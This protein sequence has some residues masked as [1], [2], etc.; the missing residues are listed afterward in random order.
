[1]AVVVTLASTALLALSLAKSDRFT[2]LRRKISLRPY[3]APWDHDPDDPD[4]VPGEYSVILHNGCTFE[5]HKETVDRQGVDLDSR[6]IYVA[7]RTYDCGAI[8]TARLDDSALAIVRADCAVDM[9]ECECRLRMNMGDSTDSDDSSEVDNTLAERQALPEPYQ[10]PLVPA[11]GRNMIPGEFQVILH[12]RCTLDEHKKH[13]GQQG[14][15]LES[16]LTRAAP[17]AQHRIVIYTARLDDSALAFVR[18]DPAVAM[19]NRLR[20]AAGEEP[21]CG[22]D[23]ADDTIARRTALP[24]PYEAPLDVDD[25][26]SIV[27]GE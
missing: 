21:D 24:E 20:Y 7:P 23:E 5:K 19:V 13:L 4:E 10:A 16:R 17:T 1:M 6:L 8:Y 9:V 22:P 27:P 3:Q 15:D 14:I 12:R 11:D 18:A 26:R 25:G 2:V